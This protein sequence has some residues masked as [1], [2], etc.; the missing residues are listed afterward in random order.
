MRTGLAFNNFAEEPMLLVTQPLLMVVNNNC[1]PGSTSATQGRKACG[2][3][4]A[5][6]LV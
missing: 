6:G 2:S 1:V 4:Q 5:L 3:R